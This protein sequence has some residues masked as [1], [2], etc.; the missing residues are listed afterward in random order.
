MIQINSLQLN[1]LN[2]T[3]PEIT[4]RWMAYF[5]NDFKL[6]PF[7]EFNFDYVIWN[8]STQN[9]FSWNYSIL[10]SPFCSNL[11]ISH[12]KWLCFNLFQWFYFQLCRFELVSF[13]FLQILYLNWK[14][15]FCIYFVCNF[16]TS[17]Y[18]T[19]NFLTC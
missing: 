18:F 2:I 4:S 5:S 6:I 1:W 11:E 13:R 16:L 14:Y 17:N 9:H 8:Y 12:V 10:N 15:T 7:K 3:S 19:W